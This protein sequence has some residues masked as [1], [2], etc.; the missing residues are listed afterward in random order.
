MRL[1]L[2]TKLII[3]IIRPDTTNV[4]IV[5]SKR[6]NIYHREHRDFYFIFF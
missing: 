1:T 4:V 2:A 5:N 3:L 6:K